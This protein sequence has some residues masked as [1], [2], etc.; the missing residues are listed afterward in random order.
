MESNEEVSFFRWIG[1]INKYSFISDVFDSSGID[2]SRTLKM[3]LH[4]IVRQHSVSSLWII[5]I[6]P[7]FYNVSETSLFCKANVL[8][9]HFWAH[10]YYLFIFLLHIFFQ[11]SLASIASKQQDSSRCSFVIPHDGRFKVSYLTC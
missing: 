1:Y 9:P 3:F 4:N 11:E 5:C 7:L 10:S 8:S 2:C 6:H